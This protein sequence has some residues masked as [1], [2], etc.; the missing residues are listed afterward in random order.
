MSRSQTQTPLQEKE[1]A[2]QA[3]QSLP[4]A[5]FSR[6]MAAWASFVR[7]NSVPLWLFFDLD[8]LAAAMFFSRAFSRW[9]P[10]VMMVVCVSEKTVPTKGN[11]SRWSECG[12]ERVVVVRLRENK[13]GELTAKFPESETGGGRCCKAARG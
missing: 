9:F 5:C 11:V 6:M 7:A 8:L 10:R 13:G 2:L 3:E 1:H 4:L 12:S